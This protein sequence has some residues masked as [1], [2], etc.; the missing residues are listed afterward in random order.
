MIAAAS[1]WILGMALAPADGGP[2][3]GDGVHHRFDDVAEW[4]KR[5]E[6]PAR[7]AW[8]RPD[9]VLRF[10][11]VGDG[12]RVADIGAGTGYFAVRAA[13]LVGP[14]GRVWGIDVEPGM[15][16]HL[17]SRARDLGLS[18]LEAIL[19]NPDDPGIPAGAADLVLIVN[20]WHHIEDRGAYLGKLRGRLRDGGRVAVVDYH[21]G[22]LPV[23]PPAGHK[24]SRD[25]VLEEFQR[26]GW[27]LAAESRDLPY[28][29]VLVFRPGD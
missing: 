17:R 26:A 8:Q 4:V 13:K 22:D 29:Y 1:L 2:Q 3:A 7:D 15:V 18:Q 19:T 23:G 27:G 10:L 16:E 11:G 21:E 28:Q 12:A 20:T 5:F 14:S 25:A 24:L 6:D 9:E